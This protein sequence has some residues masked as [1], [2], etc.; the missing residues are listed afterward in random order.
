MACFLVIQQSRSEFLP[1]LGETIGH[2]EMAVVPRSLFAIDRSLLIPRDK[3][4]IMH[5]V[6]EA[7]LG[8]Q[9]VSEADTPST[10]TP[11][12]DVSMIDDESNEF[13]DEILLAQLP[14]PDLENDKVIV[15][16]AMAVVQ[17]LKKCSNENHCRPHITVC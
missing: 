15:I 1:K 13:A 6:E 8:S 16:D 3:A 14:T 4:S 11:Q 17:C 10:N 7:K 9:A 12:P 5:T 2:Y